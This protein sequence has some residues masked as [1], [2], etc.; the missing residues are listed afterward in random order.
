MT[1]SSIGP[2]QKILYV[3][4]EWVANDPCRTGAELFFAKEVSK[5]AFGNDKEIDDLENADG[6]EE[7]HDHEPPLLSP[8][9]IM[10][11]RKPFPKNTPYQ[12]RD[13][14]R[15]QEHWKR[16]S[17]ILYRI[18]VHMSISQESTSLVISKHFIYYHRQL[19]QSVRWE[20]KMKRVTSWLSR[21]LPWKRMPYH[22]LLA[23]VAIWAVTKIDLILLSLFGLTLSTC[24]TVEISDVETVLTISRDAIQHQTFVERIPA[25]FREEIDFRAPL[26]LVAFFPRL[27]IPAVLLFS[28]L[29]GWVHCDW[30]N[31][32]VQ[33][34]AGIIL[35]IV[36]L[37]CGGAQRNILK[38]LKG[39]FASTATHT[40]FMFSMWVYSL[41][42]T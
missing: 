27:M 8:A 2:D 26:F 30:T 33:G 9:C 3:M 6:V 38:G 35:S 37:K 32:L 42:L 7:K 36:F 14:N 28:G 29:F 1:S 19:K 34:S 23:V 10:P 41:S 18:E 17:Q 13:D 21:E 24:S 25:F 40:L 11:E 22:I 4:Y 31:V 5:L 16:H 39:L 20:T 15:R 12:E